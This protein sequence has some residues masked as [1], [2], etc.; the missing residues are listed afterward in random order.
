MQKRYDLKTQEGVDFA[1]AQDV[2]G[3][4]G[5]EA[6]IELTVEQERAMIAAGWIDG[7]IE[8]KKKGG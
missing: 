5:S 4:V 7:P 6:E 1:T 8:S 3:E 2:A